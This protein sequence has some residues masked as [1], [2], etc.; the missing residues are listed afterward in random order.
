MPRL[1]INE[2]LRIRQYI[3]SDPPTIYYTEYYSSIKEN[4]SADWQQ[5]VKHSPTHLHNPDLQ[6]DR[7]HSNTTTIRPLPLIDNYNPYYPD[8]DFGFDPYWDI[9]IYNQHQLHFYKNF[10]KNIA[11]IEHDQPHIDRMLNTKLSTASVDPWQNV[12]I[13]TNSPIQEAI[14]EQLPH[15][16]PLVTLTATVEERFVNTLISRNGEPDYVP[17]TTNLGLKYKRRMLYFP[18]DF[19][20]LTL[21]GLVDTGAVSSAIPEADLR[22]IRLLAPQSIIK[23][24][25]APNFQIMVANGQLETPKSTVELKFEVGDIDFHEIFIVMEKLT[26]PLIGLSF[27]Q[28]NNTI[29]DMRQGVLN[30][31]FFSMQLKTADHKYTNVMDPICAREDITI[32][33][34]DRHM[35]SMFSQLYDDTN[36][37]G[38]IQPSNDLA[39]DGDITFCAALVTLTQGQVS[40]HV[41]NF[42]DQPYTLKRGAHIAN[43]SVL[44]PEQMKYVKP[45]DPVTT[46][47]LLKDNTENAAYYASSLIKSPK[48]S[49]DSE[50]YWF[51]TP[52]EPGDPQTHT[53]IQQ[54]ILRELRNLQD[55]E[56]L[57]P[58]DDPESRKQ[59]LAN[60]DWTDSTLNPAEIAQIEELLVEF[61]DIFARHRFDIG[62]NEDFKVTLTP[63]DD[64]PAYS[65][66]LPTPINLKE[67]ILVELALLHRYGIITTLPFSK[68]ASPIFAQKK[69]NGKLRLLV[70]LR[71]INNLISDDYINNNHPVS[72]LTDAAQHMAGKRL[73]CKLDCSQAYHCLQMA[74]QRSIEMLA[75]NFASRTF[76]YRRLA[77]GLSRAL[78]AFSSFM[79][80]YL[81]KV[82]KADQCAQYV[83]DIG[84]A[85]NDATQL[86]NNLRATFQCI[87]TAGLK[88]TMHKCHFGAKEIDFLGRTITPEGVRPQQPRVQNF[89]EK[90]KFPKSKKALQ[91]YLGILNYYRNYIPRL[92]EKLTP[93]FKLL[94][95]D[96]KVMVTPDL[97]EK[98]T[99]INKALDRCCELALKQPLPDK[100]I[101]LMTDASFSAAGYAVLIE[102]DPMEKYTS[103]RKA[104]AP[105]AYGSKTFSPAQL[106]MSIYAKEFLAIFFA[107]KE[108]G[109]IFWGTPKPV[110]ILT[111][112]KSVTR[113]FQTKIIPPTLWNA[114][115]YV[116]QFSF[117]IA[118]IPGKNNTAAD[119]LSGLEI[120]PKEK[121]ILRI[122]EDISTTPIELNVQSAGVTEE[123]QIFYTD[124]D[125]ETEEQ[126]WKRKQ[127]A[128][129]NPMNQPPDILLDHLSTHDNT[130][131]QTQNIQKLAK[132]TTMAIEQQNDL[133]LHQLRL[134]LQKDEYSE[135]ILQQDSRYRH[136]CRQIDR[137]SV[138]DD[139][140]F[141]DYYDETGSVQFRQA[142]LPKHLVTE[143][144]QSLHGSANKHPGISK[145]LHEI[146]RKYYFPGI[147]KIVKKWVQGCEI[148]IKDKRIN[149]ASITPELLN[150]P[151]W[152]LGPEDALQIDILPNLP[153]SGGYEN[154]IT[155]LD[156]FSRYLFAYP[157]T[158]ASA[159]NTAKVIIDIMTKH[160]YLPTTLIT[161]KGTAVTSKLLEEITKILGIHLRCATTKHPQTIGKLERTHASLKG[162]LKMASGEYRR[163]WHKYLPLAV[164]NYNTTYH[165]SL[166]C[167]PTRIFHGRVPYNILD[168]RLG[169]NPN[170]KITPTTDFAEEF[171]RRTQILIDQT[172][173][174][175][176]QSYLKYKEY[177]DRKAKAAPLQQGDFCFI[178]QPLAD[179]Q[180]SKIPFREFRWIG[181]YVIEKVL[182]NDNYI[183]RK[184]S[185]NK[186]Q[187]LH[188]IRLRKYTPNT[189]P[190]DIRPEG[191]L[192]AD[193]EIIIPQDDLYIISWETNFDDFPPNSENRTVTNELPTNSDEQDAI[194]TDLDLRSTRRQTNTDAA[195]A[196]DTDS[197]SRSNEI[198][199]ADLRSARRQTNTGADNT[200]QYPRN[201]HNEDR[202]SARRQQ[203]TESENDE[204]T[205]QDFPRDENS[206]ISTSGGNDTTVPDVLIEE[207]DDCVVENESPRGGRYKLRP[208]PTPNFTDE[209]RY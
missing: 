17:L 156:V 9:Q 106:K 95:S 99:E 81:D 28:R 5:Q 196:D 82:I 122:R 41:N 199:E 153:P 88:L 154:V 129:S 194:I 53:P 166:G 184:L 137:L 204:L 168:H 146:R 176:M 160:S 140:I 159:V 8:P 104:F 65:Q 59:F 38:I 18:M 142:L 58:Q 86:I 50:N 103:T 64:S 107:F 171:Q 66:S 149:N 39:E 92:S 36:V 108:F 119:Y 123:E 192:Q 197:D 178:L 167:E 203:S 43:F 180:G 93:F 7:Q 118:H 193:D 24:G 198:N 85:A 94:K 174:N 162:N 190:Q 139:I 147:A 202:Q 102:D 22:K 187:I 141:R 161:D 63:K 31:P 23:E 191:N 12:W 126:I 150:L 144:L 145:M 21:D 74:D 83:D 97:L 20:E 29:L 179:H 209:Y 125:E 19:G 109:H 170:P 112:N 27:L 60:F 124:D 16:G 67:D 208:N 48:A 76:A 13:N 101:A 151:E 115:D 62:M 127:D 135:T 195:H 72:T 181:P 26:S 136:Y 132:P 1:H 96:A 100:Q 42:T 75:F 173:K 57:N 188:R 40:I 78:S 175:I 44:T 37:T 4:S 155:A 183:V 169:L 45:I 189:T 69:P 111:D 6:S 148:C 201:A 87:R 2:K 114:C 54:R 71:K 206:E 177:Y 47:H 46:W 186:T 185:T 116:M 30:F 35:V 10:T 61:H 134:K 52:D 164:L 143:L 157:V 25:P 55:L 11:D 158:D 79:R 121:L 70:D 32:P 200:E 172:K 15:N 117:T 80:E 130:Q 3:I 120:C 14:T 91:R 33:P 77:Q 207:T 90:T 34:N 105:V 84:I 152:D 182:P 68:Y 89:L 49:D 205:N 128:R 133:I 163:Q 56:K 73:F 110:I 165:S 98:F 51:P 131:F 138:H 113:F